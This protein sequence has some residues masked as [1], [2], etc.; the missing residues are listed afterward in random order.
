MSH[1]REYKSWSHMVQRCCNKKCHAY[2]RYGGA[3]IQICDEW[4]TFQGFFE[5]MGVRP[6]GTSLDRIDGS[7]NYEPTNCR[8]A[9]IKQQNR[10]RKTPKRNKSGFVGVTYKIK[11]NR[12]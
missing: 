1:S 3:G 8:W 7:G 6:E 12:S 2:N 9:N 10:N 4:R 11:E 5:S